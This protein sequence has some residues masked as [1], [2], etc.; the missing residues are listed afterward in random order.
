MARQLKFRRRWTG[1][2]V[3]LLLLLGGFLGS[4]ALWISFALS[5]LQKQYFP[6]Y[7][8]MGMTGSAARTIPVWWIWKTGSRRKPEIAVEADLIPSA[9][10]VRGPL[11]RPSVRPRS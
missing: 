3:G 4:F 11:P 6:T 9:A 2:L 8:A 7:M 1:V 5:P 10:A